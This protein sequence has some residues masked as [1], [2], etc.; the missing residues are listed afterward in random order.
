MEE[1]SIN[2][3]IRNA[4]KLGDTNEVKRLIGDNP[5]FYIQ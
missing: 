4:I 2:K 3:T 5:K 1:K